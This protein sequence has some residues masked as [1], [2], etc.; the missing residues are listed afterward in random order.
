ML[1]AV[2]HEPIIGDRAS[3]MDYPI[4]DEFPMVVTGLPSTD[5]RSFRGDLLGTQYL[6]EWTFELAANGDLLWSGEIGW[7]GGRYEE[8]TIDSVRLIPLT[9]GDYSENGT[10][11]AGDYT[12]WRK[13][14]GQTGIG[15]AADGDGDNQVDQD[16][17]LIWRANVGKRSS[18]GSLAGAAVP[19][20]AAWA[21]AAAAMPAIL[22]RRARK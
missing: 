14:A 4:V 10:V 19:E 20:P 21:L 22:R 17:Y 9:A 3:G 6:F 16:D 15:L 7:T 12:V 2:I 5:G 18:S 13:T 1:T 11:D 8:T